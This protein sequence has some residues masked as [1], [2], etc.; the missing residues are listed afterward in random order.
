VQLYRY[1][2]SQFSD[3]CRIKLGAASQRVFIVVVFYF[4]MTQSGNI[5]IHPRMFFLCGDQSKLDAIGVT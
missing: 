2:V 1:F 5:W 3:F 4:F